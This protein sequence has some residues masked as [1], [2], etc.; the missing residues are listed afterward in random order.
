MK[1]IAFICGA[2][3]S[4]TSLLAN[5]LDG[6]P[7]TYVLPIESN[8]SYYWNL[9]KSNNS[10]ERFFLRDFFNSQLILQLTDDNTRKHSECYF[11]D[12]YG[13]I[14]WLPEKL[15]RT[16]FMEIYLGFIKAEGLSMR[17]AYIGLFKGSF[18]QKN[19]EAKKWFDDRKISVQ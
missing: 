18:L 10:L 3:R 6:H 17:N 19:N 11:R 12:K 15:N 4:G 2:A 5:L 16:E 9:Q 13:L 1:D 7:D 14:D 8:I